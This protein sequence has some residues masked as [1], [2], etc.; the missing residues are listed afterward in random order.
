MEYMDQNIHNLFIH[1]PIN[2][3]PI[4]SKV[5]KNSP[6]KLAIILP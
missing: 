1:L 6:G 2:F 5:D 3:G 4:W